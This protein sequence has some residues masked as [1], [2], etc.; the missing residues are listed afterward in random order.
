M[1]APLGWSVVHSLWLSTLIAGILAV[2]IACLGDAHAR[3]RYTLS[4]LALLAMVAAPIVMALAFLDPFAPSARQQ[5]TSV[6]DATLGF[7][8]Y[9]SWRA[10]VV[11]AAAGIWIVGAAVAAVRFIAEWRHVARLRPGHAASVDAA[12]TVDVDGLAEAMGVRQDVAVFRTR[13]AHV[14]MVFGLRTPTILLPDT[15]AS[16]L[17][18]AQVR[19]ILAH[20]LAHVSRKD[21]LANLVQIGLE[22]LLWFHPAARRVGRRI[23]TEREYCCDDLAVRIG[24]RPADYARAL[25]T[26]D[27]A[28][29]GGRLVVAAASGTLLD[30]VQRIVGEP[31]PVLTP[32]RGLLMLVLAL[33]IAA[34]V[35]TAAMVVP[36]RVELD[37]QLRQR[38]PAP[39]GTTITADGPTFPRSPR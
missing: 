11:R 4:Y 33:S 31:R 16:V 32:G 13:L 18:T 23:R 17:N 38:S 34:V 6:V 22:S 27:D 29:D 28:R 5:V 39:P 36:P 20:E 14:P 21:Y 9:V 8:S 24:T 2:V 10:I 12:L 30:R 3:A 19:A 1:L 25:A 7:S 26:L 35:V 15:T 37:A